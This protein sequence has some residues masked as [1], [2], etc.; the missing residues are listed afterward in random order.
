QDALGRTILIENL[1]R[2]VRFEASA[3]SEAEFLTRVAEAADCGLLLDLNNAYV[4][5]LNL[6]ESL[7]EFVSHLPIERVGEVHLAGFAEQDGI[8]VDTHSR[9]VSDAVWTAY[10]ALCAKA[11]DIPCL[12]EWDTDL[13][14]FTHLLHERDKAL[15]IRS[16]VDASAKSREQPYAA[17]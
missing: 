6:G 5:Q 9:P 2:Y 13:P 3:M 17:R 14:D 15:A 1:S 7:D 8:M 16:Q 10:A 12:I 4:N 11:K